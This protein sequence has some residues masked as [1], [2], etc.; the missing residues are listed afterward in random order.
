MKICAIVCEYNPFHNGHKYLLERARELSGC[1]ALVCV[2]S[3]SFT[4]RG[5]IC[6]L[7]KFLRAEHAIKGGADCVLQLPAAFSVA[8]AEIFAAGAVSIIS[9]IPDVT[10]LAFGCE[11][12][13]GESI[14][15]TAK[16]LF[17]EG[18]TFKDALKRSLGG[19]ESYKRAVA[20]ALEESGAQPG[21]ASSPNN[22][23]ALEYAKALLKAGS[24]IKIVPVE[25]T[26]A[27]YAEKELKE[28][29]SSASGIRANLCN[30][31]IAG[32]VPGYVFAAL[33]GADLKKAEEKLGAIERFAIDARGT[34]GLKK[35]FG[36]T[37]GLENKI[38]SLRGENAEEI[39]KSSTG[40]RYSSSRIRR[41]L[42]ANALSLYADD[43]KEYLAH[44]TY[45]KP[46]AV[47]ESMADEIFAALAQSELPVIVKQSDLNSLSPTA[48]KCFLSD[49]RADFVRS[50]CFG[51]SEYDYTVKFVKRQ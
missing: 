31:K 4:Q 40:K 26:G 12:A 10:H 32:N 18:G 9:K 28:N 38:Y 1:D 42:A 22:V 27:G 16:I 35:V 47:N 46:L 7:P 8:P 29:F 45:I 21:I 14:Q 30:P 49:G 50:L 24:D 17:D 37:E 34:D 6:V 5:E 13:D 41:I 20:R 19:G 23:L 3:A 25:R 43:V 39:I 11:N 44:G 33:K 2:M 51:E 36:C 48:R 15:K